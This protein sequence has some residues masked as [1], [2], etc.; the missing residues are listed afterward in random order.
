MKPIVADPKLVSF[1]GLYCGACK[2]YLMDRC[3]GC[4]ANLTATWCKIRTCCRQ[5][6]LTT[7]ADCAKAPDPADCPT[8]NNFLGK[9]FGWIFRS[10]RADCIRRIRQMGID[11]Y[12][13]EMARTRSQTVKK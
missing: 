3:Q 13:Q 4:R 8:Y 10:D 12:A 6:E 1:C 5:N 11:E 9:L 2:A 7:C